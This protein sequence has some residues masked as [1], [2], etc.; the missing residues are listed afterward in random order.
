MAVPDELFR[1]ARIYAAKQDTSVSALVAAYLRTL[2]NT[3]AEY[4][5]LAALQ[6]RTLDTIQ[7]FSA[8]DRLTRDEVHDR[9]LR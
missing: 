3:D 6:Q 5:R 9:A 4:A 2:T 8:V 7:E 1:S